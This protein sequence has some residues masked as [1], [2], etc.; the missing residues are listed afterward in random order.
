MKTSKTSS[1]MTDIYKDIIILGVVV[2]V[3]SGLLASYPAKTEA[4][5]FT[6]W[7]YFIEMMFI[8]PAVMVIMGVF[9]VFVPDEMIEKYLGRYSGFKGLFISLLFGSLPTGPLYVAF[10]IASQLIE[11]GARVS[12][13]IV[14]LSACAC[15]K[16]PQEM[17]ELHFLGA[18][19]MILRLSFTVVFV[20]AMG[21]LIEKLVLK[22]RPL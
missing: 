13:I 6:I 2:I 19:F 16:I 22:R 8:L 14:F 10:P 15:L 21:I 11:K 12:S 5:T 17:M 20:I 4:V 18:K 1:I 7:D 3:A 9:A